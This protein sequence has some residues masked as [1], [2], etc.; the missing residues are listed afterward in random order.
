MVSATA[1]AAD[2]SAG[3]LV[4]LQDNSS[5]LS[6]SSQEADLE[7]KTEGCYFCGEPCPKT[8]WNAFTSFADTGA[9]IPPQGQGMWQFSVSIDECKAAINDIT[10]TDGA[11]QL[12]RNA[13]IKMM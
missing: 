1:N 4:D 9:K 10:N 13:L 12:Y 11:Q 5:H 2:S 6:A 7:L 3:G 8:C